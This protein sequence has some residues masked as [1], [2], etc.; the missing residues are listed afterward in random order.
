M[1]EKIFSKTSGLMHAQE[2][3]AAVE[4]FVSDLFQSLHTWYVDTQVDIK[5]SVQE[6]TVGGEEKL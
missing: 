1:Y 2:S 4:G 5:G 3:G 6:M